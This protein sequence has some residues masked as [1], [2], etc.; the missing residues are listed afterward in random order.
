VICVTAVTLV[1]P[2]CHY[3]CRRNTNLGV[4]QKERS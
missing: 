3:R 1:R 4:C 2:Q